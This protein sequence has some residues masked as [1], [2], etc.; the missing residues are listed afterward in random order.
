MQCL[1]KILA[2]GQR[3]KYPIYLF[4]L[5]KGYCG[6]HMKSMYEAHVVPI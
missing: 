5:F 6:V 3:C 2:T 4:L 1:K